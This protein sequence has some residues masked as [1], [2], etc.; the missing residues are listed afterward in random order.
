[1]LGENSSREGVR[2]HSSGDLEAETEMSQVDI[3]LV[4]ADLKGRVVRV[5]RSCQET[6]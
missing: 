1:M 6:F 4:Q 2:W 3:K 5:E